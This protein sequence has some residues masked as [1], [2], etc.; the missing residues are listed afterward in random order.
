[1]RCLLA[2]R[3]RFNDIAATIPGISA[4]LLSERLKELEAEG[5][6]ERM[7]TP[8]TP[9][10]VQYRLTDKGR[11]LAAV[12]AAVSEWAETWADPTPQ[13]VATEGRKASS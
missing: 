2:G 1:M 8:E 10:R 12:V 5:V 13:R 6:V 11:D 7:V 3:T 9:V 4:R